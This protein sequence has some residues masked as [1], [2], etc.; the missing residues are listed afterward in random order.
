[1]STVADST[2]ADWPQSEDRTVD[3]RGLAIS[4]EDKAGAVPTQKK[5][6]GDAFA[7]GAICTEVEGNYVSL[8]ASPIDSDA[9]GP[10]R[11]IAMSAFDGTNG[12]AV[13]VK[14]I[15]SDTRLVG[16]ISTGSAS[17]DDVGKQGRIVGSAT[18]GLY[19]VDLTATVVASI[20]ITSCEP[21]D[22]PMN[23]TAEGDYN[24]V[25]F[26]FLDA[27]LDIAPASAS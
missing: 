25:E 15:T 16:Q 8:L 2:L 4:R 11:Y 18:T 3:T 14:T 17:E 20:E 7:I 6:Y 23:V 22:F 26:K 24:F 12:D 5:G 10:P 21:L 13:D 27:V 19:D 1:M 9:L